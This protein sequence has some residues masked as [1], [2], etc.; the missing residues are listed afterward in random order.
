MSKNFLKMT[1]RNIKRH[2]VYSFINIAGLSV[3][4][5]C[6]FLIYSY[7]QYEL[8][9]DKFHKDYKDIYR[10]VNRQIGNVYLG[11]DYFSTSPALLAPTMKED[12]SEVLKAARVYFLKGLLSYENKHFNETVHFADP[13]FFK[14]FTYPLRISSTQNPIED[15]FSML[16]TQRMAQ[17]YFG[18]QNPIGKNICLNNE[19]DFIVTGILQDTPLNSHLRFDFLLS[20]ISIKT[21][22]GGEWGQR[23]LSRWD[24]ADFH[25]YIKL[26]KGTDP[27]TL[28]EKLLAF[29]NKYLGEESP[30]CF[31]LQP[32]SSIHLQSHMNMELEPN[33]NVK[34]LFIFSTVGFL[35]L[36][37]ACFNYMNL[38]TASISHRAKEVSMRKVV[39][40]DRK[41]IFRQFLSESM[42]SCSIAF[43]SALLLIYLFLPTF[44]SIFD[45]EL[46]F[47]QFNDARMIVGLFS[48]ALFMGLL[49]G[50]YPAL[51]L[52]SIRPIKILRGNFKLSTKGSSLFRKNLVVI[53]FFISIFLIIG[54]LVI[55]KQRDFIK[56]RNLGFQKENILNV[57]IQD[58]ELR[59]N[60]Q[61]I[62]TELSNHPQILDMTVS[63]HIPARI[64][65]G[66]RSAYWEGREKDITLT[67]YR[68]S[69]D[70]NYLDFYG[71]DIV[72]GRNFSREFPS[73]QKNA[74]IVNE[75]IADYIGWE[76][77][78]GQKFSWSGRPVNGEVIGVVKNFHFFSLHMPI[79]GLAIKL[80]PNGNYLSVKIHPE[81]MENTVA[82]IEKKWKELSPEYPFVFSFLDETIDKM[83]RTEQR[84]GKSINIF[85][86]IAIFIACLG[87]FGLAS[88]TAE[89]KAKEIGIRKI[90]GA[91]I[92]N[93]IY[94][95][96]NEFLKRVL[97]AAV[98]A[99]PP[100][101][102]VMNL[103]L[104]NFAYRTNI[105]VWIIVISTALAVFVAIIT[106]C[107]QSIKVATANPVDSLR[108]E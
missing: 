102:F 79:D 75:I 44:Q 72:K 17:K 62:K 58:P 24:S 25:S 64:R 10:V 21:I 40:A 42:I 49:S 1:L 43:I 20:L 84:L 71:I 70:Y 69:V 76:D 89:Q 108:Y 104:R 63:S 101:W 22:M 27:E 34:Y 57:L 60:C 9:Y 32:I 66:S 82:F 30:S 23:Y 99:A 73:D 83:Y 77:P 2:K 35:I 37:I 97:I 19:F 45:R 78:I 4:M 61:R 107:C 50:S 18:E 41:S 88:F 95:L 91:P 16:I 86:T 11:T 7:V 36:L 12:F 47:S 51:L 14:I 53:Q 67:T 59:S 65:G 68:I 31:I 85:T 8:S 87:L 100:S 98:L 103:W 28:Q 94:L 29:K 90:L 5:A 93:I 52:S 15:P 56:S 33:S 39:G 48:I 74:Y 3:G 80:D 38:T 106:V 26:R 13:E 92:L 54:A 81:N 6:C 105:D 55:G 96:S 46:Y